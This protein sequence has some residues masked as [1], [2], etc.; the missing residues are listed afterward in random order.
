MAAAFAVAEAGSLL[1]R[2]LRAGALDLAA[3][4]VMKAAQN[5]AEKMRAGSASGEL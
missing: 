2:D 5:I 3:R 1:S 4:Q